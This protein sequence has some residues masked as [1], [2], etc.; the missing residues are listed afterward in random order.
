MNT[1]KLSLI[2]SLDIV[3]ADFGSST[4]KSH[5]KGKHAA[6]VLRI[7]DPRSKFSQMTVIPIFKHPSYKGGDTDIVIKRAFCSGLHYD[8]YANV[9]NFQV[10]ER[11]RVKRRIGHMDHEETKKMILRALMEDV[12]GV[13]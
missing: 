2:Q 3:I 1:N 6:I 5:V 8:M 4:I 7:D 12:C 13:E 11:Y 10:I 9:S